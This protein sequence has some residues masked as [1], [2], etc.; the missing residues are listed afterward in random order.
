MKTLQIIGPPPLRNLELTMLWPQLL[1]SIS[2]GFIGYHLNTT[3]HLQNSLFTSHWIVLWRSIWSVSLNLLL[4]D[5]FGHSGNS[6]NPVTLAFNVCLEQGCTILEMLE[7]FFQ[8]LLNFGSQIWLA[9]SKAQPAKCKLDGLVRGQASLLDFLG[10]MPAIWQEDS[11]MFVRQFNRTLLGASQMAG[12]HPNVL[13][14]NKE[15]HLR[16]ECR[17][18]FI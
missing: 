4:H 5:S 1:H 3:C 18:K 14:S 15:T 6:V 2:N 10:W 16:Q 7:T 12:T 11:Q 17:D 8:P 13:F 9:G